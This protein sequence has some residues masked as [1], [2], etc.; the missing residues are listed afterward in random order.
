MTGIFC[1]FSLSRLDLSARSLF[2][3]R[4]NFGKGFVIKI[5]VKNINAIFRDFSGIEAKRAAKKTTLTLF[6]A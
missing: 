4:R 3:K 5:K 6:L 2:K 1:N